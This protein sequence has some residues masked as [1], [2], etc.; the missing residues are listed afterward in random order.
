MRLGKWTWP[1]HADLMNH[2]REVEGYLISNKVGITAI[3]TWTDVLLR[4]NTLV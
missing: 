1:M 2:V 3:V 4:K